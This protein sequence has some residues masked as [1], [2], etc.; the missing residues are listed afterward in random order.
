MAVDF[1]LASV[2]SLG[3]FVLMVVY[4]LRNTGD[5]KE[6]EGNLLCKG[7]QKREAAGGY[8]IVCGNTSHRER[9]MWQQGTKTLNVPSQIIHRKQ[10]E[11]ALELQT[12][13]VIIMSFT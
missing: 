8:I 13:H 2:S 11:L 9:M 10:Y 1:C 5:A 4:P 12:E 7:R 6:A 3:F